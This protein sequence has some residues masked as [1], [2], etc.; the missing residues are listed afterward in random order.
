MV[1]HLPS[2]EEYPNPKE[3]PA[4][5]AVTSLDLHHKVGPLCWRPAVLYA[6]WPSV[7]SLLTVAPEASTLQIG[8]GSPAGPRT[9]QR[10][11]RFGAPTGGLWLP[12]ALTSPIR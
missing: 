12:T 1:E 5:G 2:L 10:P 8:S 4:P 7:E 9:G 3:T 6:P 11:H